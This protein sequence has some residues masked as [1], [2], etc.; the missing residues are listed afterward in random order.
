MKNFRR[1]VFSFL[2]F[3][4]LVG[5]AFGGLTRQDQDIYGE[6]TFAHKA[7]FTGDV[8]FDGAVLGLSDFGTGKVFY[9]NSDGGADSPGN[10][11]T[12]SA[13]PF[14]TV[15]FAIGQCTDPGDVIYPMA[16]HAESGV[17]ADLFDADVEGIFVLG[18]GNGADQPSFTFA[19]TDTTI[20]I[21]AANVTI[22]NL[23]FIAGISAIVDGISVEAAGHSFELAYC[24]FPEPTTSTFEFITGINLGALSNWANIHHN[25]Y[26]NADATGGSHFIEMGDGVNVG[27]HITDNLIFGEFLVAGIWSNKADLE[28]LIA[29]N[30]VTNMTTVQ[31]AIEFTAAATGSVIGNLARTDTQ[32]IAIDFGSMSNV[33]NLWD[34]EDTADTVAIPVIELIAREIVTVSAV[35]S[36]TTPRQPGPLRAL[37]MVACGWKKCSFNVTVLDSQLLLTLNCLPT[38]QKDQLVQLRQSFLRSSVLFRLRP[39]SALRTQHQKN[40]RITL[41]LEKLFIF[42]V[43]TEQVQVEVSVMLL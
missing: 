17:A 39:V 6:K 27:T 1:L 13:A 30:N 3:A 38:T 11:G 4:L 42:M 18:I 24:V 34:D 26:Y 21:G 25:T 41:K 40:S 15:D 33:N 12:T 36:Q 19:D 23:R 16:G 22:Y 10:Y 32:A 14:A 5:P 43:M 28:T 31:F 9:V 2:V 7:T 35:L 37:L 20:A 8:Q 29:R